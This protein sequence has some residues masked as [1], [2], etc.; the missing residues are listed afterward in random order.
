[1][2]LAGIDIGTNTL[3][4]LIADIGPGTL[5]EIQSARTIARLGEDLDR[6][7]ILSPEAQDRAVKA[8]IDF[9]ESIEQFNAARVQAVGT[10][11]LRNA[12]N[13]TAFLARVRA[14]TGIAIQVI[15]GVQEAKLTVLG[16]DA[17]L[18][19]Q[20]RAESGRT[21]VVDIG[22]GSTEI[23]QSGG[24][25]E[26][27]ETSLPL[28]AVYLT[29][30]FIRHDPPLREELDAVRREISQKL[31]ASIF[32]RLEPSEKF[33]VGTAGTIT[34]LSA[35]DQQLARYD[36]EKI[37]GSI[38]T[39]ETID[40]MILKL[41]RSPISERRKIPG[42]EQ[43]REDIILAGAIVIQAIMVRFGFEKML[44]S[45]WGLRE[46]ILL[47]LYDRIITGKAASI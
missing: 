3:R 39:R 34:T 17:A 16:V 10:S 41:G 38:L 27:R 22:G 47:D 13:A 43:G 23:V 11:A 32:N 5:R 18:S 28:G 33:L 31:E 1:M 44:V 21:L 8:L 20:I 46:G 2:I 12:T 7:G 9:K 40:A 14:T 4:L 15:S 25:Q 29:E 24:G 37:N 45:D 26:T 30:R 36:P 6:T 42:L 19:G 35:M